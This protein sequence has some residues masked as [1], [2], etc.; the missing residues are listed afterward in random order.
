MRLTVM[1]G[2]GLGLSIVLTLGVREATGSSS[3]FTVAGKEGIDK[4]VACHAWRQPDVQP[5]ELKK[6]HDSLHLSH[7]PM[8]GPWCDRCHDPK[9]P[10][11]LTG[12]GDRI[13]SFGEAHLL[14]VECHGATVRDWRHGAH[15]KRVG[16]WQG[17]ASILPCSSCHDPHRPAWK[18]IPPSAPPVPPGTTRSGQ[19]R[20]V[21]QKPPEVAP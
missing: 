7:W 2:I 1:A 21:P 14:C 6:P 4:C 8:P 20:I 13:L 12:Y 10:R 5:R 17:P 3:S 9:T 19:S 18:P 16:S 15:G 11:Q